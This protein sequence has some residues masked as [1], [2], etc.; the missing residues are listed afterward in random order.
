[1]GFALLLRENHWFSSDGFLYDTSLFH[2]RGTPFCGKAV[3]IFCWTIP[4]MACH[5]APKKTMKTLDLVVAEMQRY[6]IPIGP[7]TRSPW[8]VLPEAPPGAPQ[9]DL[10]SSRLPSFQPKE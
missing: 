8:K 1:M 3:W 10:S 4:Y 7:A 9:A 2:G 5:E 6:P